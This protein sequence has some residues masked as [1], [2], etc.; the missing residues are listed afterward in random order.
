M[1]TDKSAA[2][3]AAPPTRQADRENP[4]AHESLYETWGTSP[5]AAGWSR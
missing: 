2:N 1:S 5:R 4:R 3:G